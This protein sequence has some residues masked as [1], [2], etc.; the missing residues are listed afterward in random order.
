MDYHIVSQGK[1]TIPS[2]ADDEEM[3]VTDVRRGL[4]AFS[5]MLTVLLLPN[6]QSHVQY[7]HIV[8]N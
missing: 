4:N 3:L 7:Y 8:L 1:T 2:V 5:T 6:G